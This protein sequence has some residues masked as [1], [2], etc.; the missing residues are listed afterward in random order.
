[1]IDTAWEAFELLSNA[2]A[3]H[4]ARSQPG[5]SAFPADVDKDLY[6]ERR[7]VL[8]EIAPRPRFSSTRSDPADDDLQVIA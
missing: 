2:I 5:S 1:M 4:Q 8:Q 6:A 7:R 3:R